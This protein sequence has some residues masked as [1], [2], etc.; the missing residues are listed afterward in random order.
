MRV[1]SM[2][3]GFLFL[4]GVTAVAQAGT[5]SAP[6]MQNDTVTLADGNA[7]KSPNSKPEKKK[8]KKKKAKKETKKNE[9]N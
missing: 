6:G 7:D 5:W 4:V 2:M 1:L 9:N 3:V 8:E